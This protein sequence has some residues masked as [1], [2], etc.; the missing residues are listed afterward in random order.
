MIWINAARG[1][2]HYHRSFPVMHLIH[3]LRLVL[4]A[5]A[6]CL[7]T[8]RQRNEGHPVP[9]EVDHI[10]RLLETGFSVLEELLVSAAVR[11][12]APYV[13]INPLLGGLD[14]VVTTIVGP[15]VTVRTSLGAAESR[16]YGRKV[17]IERILLNVVFNAVAAM[18]SG[19]ALSIETELTKSSP[20]NQTWTNPAT[21]FGSLR[22]TIRDNGRGMSDAE[23]ATAMDPMAKPRL[24][25]SGLGLASVLLILTRLGG[26][27]S[28]ESQPGKGTAI[29]IVLP[30]SPSLSTH[31]H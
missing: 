20:D 5:I 30:L 13:E 24:D 23:L 31:V 9:K 14:E 18:P 26:T 11:P 21:P 29:V 22:L 3:D 19:G 2:G 16:V 8:L 6:S 17:D 7:Q 12:D 25:G 10:G 28:I 4:A 1:M 15:D 27:V